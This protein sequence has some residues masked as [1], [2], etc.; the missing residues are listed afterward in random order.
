MIKAPAFR[1]SM[2]ALFLVAPIMACDSTTEPPKVIDT[3]SK[4]IAPP[5][6]DAAQSTVKKAP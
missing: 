5:A 1:L 4:P 3:T 6:P 2:L